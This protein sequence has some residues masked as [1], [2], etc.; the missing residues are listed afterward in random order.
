MIQRP[1]YADDADA[2]APH[3]YIIHVWKKEINGDIHQFWLTQKKK[4]NIPI[5]QVKCAQHIAGI[6]F[7]DDFPNRFNL[8]CNRIFWKSW[9]HFNSINNF[10]I[11]KYSSGIKRTIYEMMVLNVWFNW[12][13]CGRESGKA[14]FNRTI[15]RCSFNPGTKPLFCHTFYAR[16]NCQNFFSLCLWRGLVIYFVHHHRTTIVFFFPVRWRHRYLEICYLQTILYT[17]QELIRCEL[18][19]FFVLIFVLFSVTW[20]NFII[21]HWFWFWTNQF[22]SLFAKHLNTNQYER[23]ENVKS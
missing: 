10:L 22:F 20:V 11:I 6:C 18:E 23:K 13:D 15:G 4:K 8:N 17:F 19:L 7:K 9:Q 2:A 3:I 21:F 14:F 12:I 1:D 5:S 16:T